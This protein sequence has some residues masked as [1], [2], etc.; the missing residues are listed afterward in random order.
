MLV[1]NIA[2]PGDFSVSARTDYC[3]PAEKE[4]FYYEVMIVTA[5]E[6]K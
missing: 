5:G 3:M 2:F 1:D 4:F 6:N